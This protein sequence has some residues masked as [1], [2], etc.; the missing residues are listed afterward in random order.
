MLLVGLQKYLLQICNL[1]I[2]E[3][4]LFENI[5]NYYMQC[6][7]NKEKDEIR[8]LY[9][10]AQGQASSSFG[11]TVGKMAGLPNEVIELAKIKA[12]FMNN[13]KRNIGFE[14]NIL[15]KFNKFVEFLEKVE[16]E[17]DQDLID[18]GIHLLQELI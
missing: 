7:V 9:K 15:V 17:E 1:L 3:F 18:E 5:G 12:E 4:K 13:E 11:I 8:F 2:D 16:G 6:E 10:F 14:T